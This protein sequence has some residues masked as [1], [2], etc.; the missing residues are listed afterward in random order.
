MNK[1]RDNKNKYKEIY[2]NI[3]IDV[4][5]NILLLFLF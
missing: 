3:L 5:N 1:I 2:I 4:N